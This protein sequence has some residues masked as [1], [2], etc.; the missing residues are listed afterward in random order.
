MVF[1]SSTTSV[2]GPAIALNYMHIQMMACNVRLLYH[3]ALKQTLEA[4]RL[5]WQQC[6]IDLPTSANLAVPERA[7]VPRL[8]IRSSRVMP[9]PVSLHSQ[10]A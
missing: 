9:T 1:A 10:A 5:A 8:C 6:V 7:I 4:H 2:Q 3:D